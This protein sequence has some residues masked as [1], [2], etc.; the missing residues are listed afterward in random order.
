MCRMQQRDEFLAAASSGAKGA[1]LDGYRGMRSRARQTAIARLF[2][3]E[4]AAYEVAYEAANRPAWIDVPIARAGRSRSPAR[5]GE[6]A[7]HD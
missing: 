2:L 7:S 6:A 3:I 1:F 5:P 4:K